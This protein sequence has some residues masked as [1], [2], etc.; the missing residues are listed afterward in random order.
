MYFHSDNSLYTPPII[1]THFLLQQ[2]LFYSLLSQKYFILC[3][4]CILR[5]KYLVQDDVWRSI[6]HIKVHL[7][8]LFKMALNLTF[9]CQLQQKP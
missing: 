2:S 5:F 4:T 3:V 7:H 6:N 1:I 9:L 8:I